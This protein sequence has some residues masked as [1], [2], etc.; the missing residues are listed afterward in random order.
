MEGEANNNIITRY[1]I[2]CW[3]MRGAMKKNKAGKGIERDEVL[4]CYFRWRKASLRGVK[5]V[6]RP[7]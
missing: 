7:D 4:G 2:T 6:Q 5:L 1:V 3:D